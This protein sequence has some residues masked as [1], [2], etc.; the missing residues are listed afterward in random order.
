MA[1]APQAVPTTLLRWTGDLDL[2][3]A[4]ELSASVETVDLVPLQ[5]VVVDLADVTFMD[6]TGL[7]ALVRLHRRVAA[8]GGALAVTR[9]SP[10]VAR[11]LD[12]TGLN[13]LF[14]ADEAP[15]H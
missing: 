1:S 11:L 4:D 8:V 13:A 15:S 7:N 14:Q 3:R 2:A 12:L 10:R 9:P 6:S 5:R